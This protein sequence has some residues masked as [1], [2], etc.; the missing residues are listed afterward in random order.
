MASACNSLFFKLTSAKLLIWT[1]YP[2]H[3]VK[4]FPFFLFQM[5]SNQV[6]R[7]IQHRLSQLLEPR[8]S[9]SSI[10]YILVVGT[11][12][13]NFLNPV[14]VVHWDLMLPYSQTSLISVV[15]L[16]NWNLMFPRSLTFL[17]SVKTLYYDVRNPIYRI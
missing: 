2:F 17:S 9:M 11:S 5:Q 8:I 6:H 1:S 3:I 15:F 16:I 4:Y 14:Y 10:Q 13:C 12:Y 7:L